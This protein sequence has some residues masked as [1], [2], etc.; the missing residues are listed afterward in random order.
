MQRLV[1]V[2]LFLFCA[3]EVTASNLSTAM[4]FVSSDATWKSSTK[5]VQG[6]EQA[7][8][9]DSSWE[10]TRSPSAGACSLSKIKVRFTTPMWVYKGGEFLTAYFRKTFTLNGHVKNAR[11][12]AVFDDDGDIYING[13]KVLSDTSGRAEA[14]PIVLDVST[15]FREGSNTLAVKVKDTAGGKWHSA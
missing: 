6:W 3:T 2:F 11:I 1:I 15:H 7:E 9:D 14:N 10:N 5:L 12:S 4:M 8:F 13:V